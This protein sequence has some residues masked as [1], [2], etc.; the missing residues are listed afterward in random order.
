MRALAS[1]RTPRSSCWR[2]DSR[3]DVVASVVT[4]LLV[5]PLVF[6]YTKP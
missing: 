3:A 2:N 1:W 5:Q 4:M 6:G